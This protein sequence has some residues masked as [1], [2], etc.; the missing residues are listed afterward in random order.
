MYD[1]MLK[2]LPTDLPMDLSSS[3]V[4]PTT[5]LRLITPTPFEQ[6]IGSVHA[7]L[8]MHMVPM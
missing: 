2:W 5:T 3:D 6:I 7:A 1:P 8:H 4:Q